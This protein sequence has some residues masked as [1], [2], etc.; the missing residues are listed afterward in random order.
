MPVMEVVVEVLGEREGLG[1]AVPE[2]ERRG[3]LLRLLLGVL[4]QESLGERE[5]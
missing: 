1:E 4:V 3:L 5:A 2:V